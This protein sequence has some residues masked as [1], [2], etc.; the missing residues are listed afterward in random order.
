MSAPDR[1]TKGHGKR[2]GGE[3]DLDSFLSSE[4][5]RRRS[6]YRKVRC[7]RH[8]WPAQRT[9]IA[10]MMLLLAGF[11]TVFSGW[12]LL[13][14][15]LVASDC[16][17]AGSKNSGSTAQRAVALI[18]QLGGQYPSYNLAGNISPNYPFAKNTSETAKNAGF[19]FEYYPAETATMDFFANLPSHNY[20]IVI[21][22]THGTGLVA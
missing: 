3:E 7:F 11:L 5:S 18:D 9:G 15:F 22:R 8:S 16:G 1:K 20:S 19:G 10:L 14:M 4:L 17:G 12:H 6:Q 2:S 21:L 13:S